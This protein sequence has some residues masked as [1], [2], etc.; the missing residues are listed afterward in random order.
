[1]FPAWGLRPLTPPRLQ[2]K[3]KTLGLLSPLPLARL[4]VDDKVQNH[5]EMG[6]EVVREQ[7]EDMPVP[8]GQGSGATRTWPLGPQVK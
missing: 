5:D 7:R 8:L 4:G 2:V 6:Q 3:E 1:M